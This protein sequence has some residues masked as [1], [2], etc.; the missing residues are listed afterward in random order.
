MKRL[1][2]LL[3][4]WICAT[5]VYAQPGSQRN[6]FN[7]LGGTYIPFAPQPASPW[8]D[9]MHARFEFHVDSTLLA[10]SM[11]D[12]QMEYSCNGVIHTIPVNVTSRTFTVLVAPGKYKFQFLLSADYLELITDSLL[13]NGGMQ[14]QVDLFFKPNFHNDNRIQVLK[15][16][17]Y[18]YS[19]RPQETTILLNPAGDFTF[20]Y[21]AYNE[22][23]HGTAF[24][25]GSFQVGNQRYPYLFWEGADSQVAQHADYTSGFIVKGTDAIAF[26]EKQLDAMGFNMR[27]KTDFITFWGP[28]IAA[29]ETNFV[30]FMFNQ[31]YDKIAQLQVQPQ[32]ASVFRV[33]ML[34]T[35]LPNTH[36]LHPIAP[37]IPRINREGFHLLEWGGSRLP[38]QFL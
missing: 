15:P 38:Y 23:W 27:E 9:Q 34:L 24:P 10:N 3:I 16:V 36:N 35:P 5:S 8:L 26:L 1:S 13:I 29:Q 7:V 18:C 6:Q 2:F 25:D 28:Q 21:P 17:I 14:M 32:P 31:D 4:L 20:T 30:Q 33:Y 12:F 22:N 19:P 37:V 11:T